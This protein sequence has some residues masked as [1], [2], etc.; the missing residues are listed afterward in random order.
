MA[1]R[2]YSAEHQIVAA[3]AEIF[4]QADYRD[5]IFQAD[6]GM[7]FFTVEMNMIVRVLFAMAGMAAFCKI[8]HPVYIGYL[9]DNAFF[10]QPFQ[11]PVDGYPVAQITDLFLDIRMG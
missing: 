2:A 8:Y 9:M 5:C 4:G 3:D 10:L 1:F 11:N 6:Y 7:A